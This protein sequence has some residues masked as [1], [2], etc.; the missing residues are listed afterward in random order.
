MT[1]SFRCWIT[2]HYPLI[3]SGTW[4]SEKQ[5]L[6]SH[7]LQ[8]TS[9]TK[10][11]DSISQLKF[12]IP[13]PGHNVQ[14]R[15]CSSTMKL[16]TSGLTCSGLLP[17]LHF[18]SGILYGIDLFVQIYF[19]NNSILVLLF[20]WILLIAI[21]WTPGKLLFWSMYLSILFRYWEEASSGRDFVIILTVVVLYQVNL[22]RP[23]CNCLSSFKLA[24]IFPHSNLQLFFLIQAF[25][26][27]QACMV[28]SAIFHTFNS[29]S[30]EASE[31]CLMLDLGGIS[32]S[33]TASYISGKNITQFFVTCLRVPTIGEWTYVF[34]PAFS[35][36]IH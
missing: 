26:H 4:L 12:C 24:T 11:F 14:D 17:F 15:Y 32:C 8:S 29:H 2:V 10:D 19:Q 27:H 6:H 20:L 5:P 18:C 7:R 3:F 13:R 21:Q 35:A 28:L 34:D 33:I 36:E 1:D 25:P 31:F 22:L 30:R 9:G 23:T 16:S